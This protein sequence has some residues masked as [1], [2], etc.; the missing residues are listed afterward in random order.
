MRTDFIKK[1]KSIE[2]N[3]LENLDSIHLE[4]AHLQSLK[5]KCKRICI[6]IYVYM[7][8]LQIFYIL[9]MFR[10]DFHKLTVIFINLR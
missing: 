1:K 5:D 7:L 6:Y 2:W 10:L 8:I 3:Y 9:Y 4:P